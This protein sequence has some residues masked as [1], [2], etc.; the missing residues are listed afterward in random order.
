MNA[1]M[2]ARE[3]NE[4]LNHRFTYHPPFG[5]QAERYQKIREAARLLAFLIVQHSPQSREQSVALTK[6]DEVVF[7]TNASIARNEVNQNQASG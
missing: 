1:P 2:S 6:L 3:Q 5:D 4:M 7:W